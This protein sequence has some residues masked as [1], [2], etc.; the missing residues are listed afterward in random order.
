MHMLATKP[1][2]GAAWRTNCCLYRMPPKRI[3]RLAMPIQVRRAD[4]AL[5]ESAFLIE[6][7]RAFEWPKRWAGMSSKTYRQIADAREALER[8]EEALQAL[9]KRF[10]GGGEGAR[11]AISPRSRAACCVFPRQNNS[12][13][14][15]PGRCSC[16]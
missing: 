15:M 14:G 13:R 1:I 2:G 10:T 7:A 11:N 4:E 5:R 12:R 16:A 8:L 3:R 9:D 6:K